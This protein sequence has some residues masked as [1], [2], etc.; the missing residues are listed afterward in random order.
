[1]RRGACD[2][3]RRRRVRTMSCGLEP[4]LNSAR[5][6]R[7]FSASGQSLR[8]GSREGSPPFS[9]TLTIRPI[10]AMRSVHVEAKEVQCGVQARCC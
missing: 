5:D 10:E 8:S 6:A 2:V 1:M 4:P 3:G 7:G 9:R